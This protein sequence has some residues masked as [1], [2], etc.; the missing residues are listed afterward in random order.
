MT[1]KS[2]EGGS[3][4]QDHVLYLFGAGAS[5]KTI[6]VVNDIP[7]DM[8]KVA[9]KLREWYGEHQHLLGEEQ[10]RERIESIHKALDELA[11]AVKNF[12][13]RP[14]AITVNELA[15]AVKNSGNRPEAITVDEYISSLYNH[16]KINPES[17]EKCE[18]SRSTLSAYILLKQ[19][20]QTDQDIKM[21]WRYGDWLREIVGGGM[22]AEFAKKIRFLTW[23]YDFQMELSYYQHFFKTDAESFSKICNAFL[24]PRE[25]ISSEK[26]NEP[27]S[28]IFSLGQL[29]IHLNGTACLGQTQ[30]DDAHV[31]GNPVDEQ[32]FSV[33]QLFSLKLLD[34]NKAKERVREEAKK[35]SVRLF[36]NLLKWLSSYTVQ[37]HWDI[38]NIDKL[39]KQISTMLEKVECMVVVG[40]SFPGYNQR[41]DEFIFDCVK[42]RIKEK[43][44]DFKIYIQDPK[45][46]KIAKKLD[47]HFGLS[48][49]N[50]IPIIGTKSFYIPDILR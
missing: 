19:I 24:C 10:E 4:P 7:D 39:K 41:M 48:E 9:D 2:N 42:K 16:G 18:K 43:G 35:A 29:G 3:V 11:D 12:G 31:Q 33:A 47:W 23:N 49:E 1:Y 14:G 32:P 28:D 46:K 44:E 50:V 20:F 13:N 8:K 45:P 38:Q 34:S 6:P 15:D 37:F 40:Y 30:A 21:D 22:Q 5:A 25:S 36:R 17:R 27:Q 26:K